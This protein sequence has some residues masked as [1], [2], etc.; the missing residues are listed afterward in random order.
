MRV[1]A[2]PSVQ[3]EPLRKM[4]LVNATS[5]VAEMNHDRVYE[6]CVLKRPEEVDPDVRRQ[7]REHGVAYCERKY[8]ELHGPITKPITTSQ[9]QALLK[10][11]GEYTCCV[12]HMG[13]YSAQYEAK[14]VQRLSQAD[15][16]AVESAPKVDSRQLARSV[17]RSASA[18]ILKGF[19]DGYSQT[20]ATIQTLISREL[21]EL[22]DIR[23][24]FQA[25][26]AQSLVISYLGDDMQWASYPDNMPT[27]DV[28]Q[29]YCDDALIQVTSKDDEKL[30]DAYASEVQSEM[31]SARDTCMGLQA[32]CAMAA[33]MLGQSIALSYVARHV[34]CTQG[35]TEHVARCTK[36][37]E[38]FVAAL[39]A[40]TD[41]A[42][43]RTRFYARDCCV[44]DYLKW[45]RT[46]TGGVFQGP[47]ATDHA[48]IVQRVEAEVFDM[49]L[50]FSDQVV[51]TV[52]QRIREL[53]KLAEEFL[54]DESK[55]CDKLV[56]EKNELLSSLWE[57]EPT[58]L[59]SCILQY[60]TTPS[61]APPA[62]QRSLLD[63]TSSVT[64]LLNWVKTR[65]LLQ[66]TCYAHRPII[67]PQMDV[68]SS[69]PVTGAYTHRQIMSTALQAVGLYLHHRMVDSGGDM[70]LGAQGARLMKILDG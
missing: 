48:D 61:H 41:Q 8:K 17:I 45:R 10:R 25:S 20:Y 14:I 65:P 5:A 49:N 4:L 64:A 28:V 33:E 40:V 3:D 70:E 13:F 12:P 53:W 18:C 31:Q 51:R 22:R 54:M 30:I 21:E 66:G 36:Y 50:E 9:A 62:F 29:A 67:Q 7:I 15:A 11:V 52:W 58:T 24:A 59:V 19:F 42:P 6:I 32:R 37:R 43:D 26:N 16:K 60:E 57:G 55:R 68:L 39:R 35:Y 1:L 63:F 69:G 46:G 34:T 2:D 56:A 38:E 23:L 47:Q 44:Q 27:Q